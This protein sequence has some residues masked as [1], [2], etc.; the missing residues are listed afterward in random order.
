MKKI[1][2]IPFILV[3]FNTV[4]QKKELTLKDAVSQ[5]WRSFRPD[6]VNNFLWIPGT[7]SYSYLSKNWQTLYTSSVG[8]DKDLE[9]LTIQQVNESMK[10]QFN[11]FMD[12]KWLDKEQFILND[13]KIYVK[14]NVST[15][16]GEILQKLPEA[17]ENATPHHASNNIAYTIEHNLYLNG[18][19]ITKNKNRNIVS[20]QSIARNEFGISNGIFWSE[21]GNVLAFYQKNEANVHDY[22]LLNI[23]ETPGQLVSIKYPMAGQASE[24]PKIGIYN[25]KKN[26]TI[27]I[28][29]K[30]AIDDYFTNVSITPDEKYLVVAEVNRD[31]NRMWLNV[32]DV[33]KGKYLKTLHEETNAKWVE[34]EHPAY[35]TGN[36]NDFLWLS[37][38]DGYMNIYSVDFEGNVAPMQLTKHIFVVKD[39][40]TLSPD[41]KYIY[42]SA[43]GEN[44]TNTLVYKTD[45]SG[46]SEVLTKENGTHSFQL[47]SDGAYWFNAFSSVSIPN[48]TL[49]WTSNG[50][51]AKGLGTAKDKLEDY[52]IGTTEIG[53]IKG[54]DGSDLYYR[55]IKPANFNPTLKYPVMVYVYGGPHAQMVTNSWLAGA[56]LWMHWMANQGYI[57]FTLDNRGS[58]ERGFAF[59]SQIH[60]Q[61]G[62]VEMEDQLTGVNYLKGLPFVDAKR[63]A[64]H[65]WSFG[66]FMTTS[67]ML[68]QPG[69]FTTG[70]AGGPVTDW[71]FY[72]IMYG[73]RY[74]D[75]PKQ[76]KEGYE[77]ASLLNYADKLQGNLLLI[78]G[79]I[80]DVVVM[81]HNYALVK[82]FVEAGKQMDFFPYPMHKH[83]VS[84]KDRVH[85]MEKILSYILEKNK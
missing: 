37:E 17:A 19:A 82:K 57:V 81:Q 45:F 16:T 28:A 4:A 8:S 9:V 84:G 79:T 61:L 39:I 34:P 66:G 38:K 60:R 20:G 71:K 78:H 80:D 53:K 54:N 24:Q 85:L 67:L 49:I 7:D 44:P 74:M 2:L 47:S 68:R 69:V 27:Y 50:K 10:T 83:N 51:M 64:V 65:G 55:M 25:V 23:D 42:Y 22:P 35:Y 30:G 59:E 12:L 13:G 33:K 72:E 58:A 32:Y 46:N 18:K 1:L 73:E 62:T 3:V 21:K 77:K 36:G 5:Q 41:K 48:K 76:N 70:V 6:Y 75:R 43:T 14:F 40:L 31:Q 52:N 26:K 15:K 63:M 29:P 11:G 56:N